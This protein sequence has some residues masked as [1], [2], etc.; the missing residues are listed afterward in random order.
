MGSGVSD[1]TAKLL[2][3]NH[4]VVSYYPRYTYAEDLKCK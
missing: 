1:W 3:W 2:G 4:Q